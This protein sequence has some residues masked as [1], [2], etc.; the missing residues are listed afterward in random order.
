MSRHISPFQMVSSF[1]PVRF[2]WRHFSIARVSRNQQCGVF[3]SNMERERERK[4]RREKEYTYQIKNKRQQQKYPTSNKKVT[5]TKDELCIR[6]KKQQQQQIRDIYQNVSFFIT[7]FISFDLIKVLFFINTNKP[8]FY[9]FSLKWFSIRRFGYFGQ[10]FQP[11]WYAYHS[12]YTKL[13]LYS[14]L[15][16]YFQSIHGT[17]THTQTTDEPPL[18]LFRLLTFNLFRLYTLF[19]LF[20]QIIANGHKCVESTSVFGNTIGSHQ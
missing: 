1:S 6:R 13:C 16:T 20:Q 18:Y 4:K 5:T 2:L 15:Q 11:K 3:T 12:I 14:Y 19:S 10:Y 17:H 8:N 7:N 9:L